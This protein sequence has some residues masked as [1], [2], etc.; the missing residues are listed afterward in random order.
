[1]AT[2]LTAS[3]IAHPDRL[4]IGGDWV[5]PSTDRTFDLVNPATEETFF[6]IA[7]AVVADVHNAIAAA[8]KAFDEGPW[9]WLPVTERAAYLRAMS[10]YLDLR[11]PELAAAWTNQMGA[12]HAFASAMVPF[13][14]GLFRDFATIGEDF[15]FIERRVSQMPAIGAGGTGTAPPGLLVREPVGVVAAIVPWNTPLSAAT[16][17]LAP[18]LIAGCTVILKP[19]PETPIDAYIIAE[20]AAAVGLPKGVLNVVTADRAAA[21]ELVRHPDVDKVS[22]TGSSAAG[23][24][25]AA[26]CGERIARCTLELGGKS[27]AVVLD[28]YDPAA[29]AAAVTGSTCIL[30]NQV[31][32]ALSRVIVTRRRHADLVDALRESFGRVRVG[33]PYDPESA[34]GPLAMKRQLDRVHGYLDKARAEGTELVAGG[35][36]PPGHNHGY[37]VE[38]T[39]F[40]NVSND[41]TIAREEIFGPVIAVI[42]AEDEDHAVRLA[43]DSV[44]GLNSAVFTNDIECAYSVGRR[45]RAGTVGHNAFKMDLSIAFGGFKQSGIGR[46]GGREGLLPFL[47]TKTMLID[48][49]PARY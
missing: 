8:R 12:V 5:T 27:A 36:R 20:A 4:F 34:M 24:R 22:F 40:A 46:E 45:L 48:G 44:F 15:D 28:D 21:E 30:S 10:D 39:I 38:P 9:P 17:K 19:A 23:K 6:S 41:S 43:N 1:M 32:A 49:E 16:V 13:G 26:L 33:D 7:E 37:Y 3:A 31:C 11:H 47:E 25:I 14:S 18:A 35:G 2:T 29:V 42:P